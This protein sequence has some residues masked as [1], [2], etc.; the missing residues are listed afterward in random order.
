MSDLSAF[1]AFLMH[2][3]NARWD[4]GL[5]RVPELGHGVRPLSQKIICTTELF[6]R[7]IE[8]AFDGFRGAFILSENLI[9]QNYMKNILQTCVR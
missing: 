8:T 7:H 5:V 1:G 4:R 6:M 9:S 3:H 2:R